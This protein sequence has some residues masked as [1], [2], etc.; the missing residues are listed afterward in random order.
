MAA[1]TPVV[2]PSAERRRAPDRPLALV[3]FIWSA[4]LIWIKLVRYVRLDANAIDLS[5]YD[6]A[7]A[8]TLAGHFMR[9][10][11][12]P[13]H[14]FG[15]HLS[16]SLLLVL[17]L[18]AL[19]PHAT[20]LLVAQVLAVAL[21]AWLWARLLLDLDIA[22]WPRLAFVASYLL[23]RPTH[24]LVAYGFHP[25]VLEPALAFALLLAA[26]RRRWG[27]FALSVV[28]ALGVKEDMALYL[29]PVGLWLWL[30]RG[31]RRAGMLT[32]L[33]AAAW[34][35]VALK[36][37]IP[38][39][40]HS[41]GFADDYQYWGNWEAASPSL[42]GPKLGKLANLYWPLLCL[43]LLA[44]AEAVL[45]LL[46]V[47]VLLT[48]R[49]PLQWGFGIYYVAPFLAY[50]FAAA[51][52]SYAR[53]LERFWLWPRLIPS[54]LLVVNLANSGLWAY[55]RH[56]ERLW[57]DQASR[58]GHAVLAG[59]PAGATVLAQGNLY[60]HLPRRPG[61]YLLGVDEVATDYAVFDLAGDPYPYTRDEI[62]ARIASL[63]AT[64]D[65][66]RANGDERFV[67]LRAA[68]R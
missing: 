45:W 46:P 56:P 2:L 57:P 15:E 11:W 40:R 1:P 47:A 17:P 24:A 59:I 54:L 35:V 19:H 28:L 33:A 16:P 53:L 60:P 8:N 6:Q 39:Y 61:I 51:A 30:E 68:R 62:A 52:R 65:Y 43:P 36:L 34:F 42:L 31:E 13:F 9:F 38:A 27:W 55:A 25:E 26:R 18:Y 7:L 4:L 14:H 64:G 50:L 49:N 66:E 58:R 22:G 41:Q 12:P 44:P 21:S 23:Y 20:T 67:L 10:Q 63:T 3:I 37:V 29:I 5:Y 32:S 48:S